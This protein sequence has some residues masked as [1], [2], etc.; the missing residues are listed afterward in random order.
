M[1]HE[2][3]GEKQRRETSAADSSG[4]L[5][6]PGPWTLDSSGRLLEAAEAEVRTPLTGAAE[7]PAQSMDEL[8][9]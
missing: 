8:L 7:Q 3:D 9:E 2:I 5:L 6:D 1:V 4:R